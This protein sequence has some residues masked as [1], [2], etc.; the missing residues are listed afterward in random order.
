M[1]CKR[2]HGRLLIVL[3][4]IAIV[5]ILF[6]IYFLYHRNTMA[7]LVQY[8][9]DEKS[10][11]IM[12][13]IDDAYFIFSLTSEM[14]TVTIPPYNDDTECVTISLWEIPENKNDVIRFI[15]KSRKDPAKQYDFKFELNHSKTSYIERLDYPF[16]H[17]RVKYEYIDC[18]CPFHKIEQ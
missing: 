17:G 12:F 6:G 3:A 15:L 18:A 14:E 10:G 16:A 5:V 7:N 1:S 9:Y 11:D 13:S 4:C 2:T 8:E